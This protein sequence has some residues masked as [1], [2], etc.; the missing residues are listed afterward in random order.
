MSN[1]FYR[2]N[3][4]IILTTRK[5]LFDNAL[6]KSNLFNNDFLNYQFEKFGLNSPEFNDIEST[7]FNSISN[8][9]RN[10]EDYN[11]E[12]YE[13]MAVDHGLGLLDIDLISCD[14]KNKKVSN[15]GWIWQ[16]NVL[17]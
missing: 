15:I 7:F 12:R 3:K 1:W 9:L 10:T 16:Q 8:N 11:K 4:K 13:R 5:T 17:R 14:K 2:K 6:I